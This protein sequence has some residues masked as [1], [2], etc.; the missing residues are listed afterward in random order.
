MARS[1][2]VLDNTPWWVPGVT[3]GGASGLV[4]QRCTAY[5]E[6]H[7]AGPKHLEGGFYDLRSLGPH[8]WTCKA[9]ADVRVVMACKHGHKGQPQWLCNGHREMIAKRGSGVCPPC[10][11]PPEELALQ[12][13][14]ERI[15]TDP[16]NYQADALERDKAQR[17]AVSQLW[18]IQA[19][20][21][22]LVERGIV[23][24]CPLTMT[25]TS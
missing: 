20:L 17:R 21:N 13:R 23:H 18:D 12:E 15:R 6:K 4:V 9:R 19:A 5:E 11:H 25:E 10:A 16:A 8:V 14:M 2:D 22:E 1:P 3:T 24:R 7:G